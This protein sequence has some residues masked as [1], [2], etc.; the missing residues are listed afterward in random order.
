MS[1]SATDVAAMQAKVN[2]VERENNRLRSEISEMVSTVKS[3]KSSVSSVMDETL[4]VLKTGE[5]VIELDDGKLQNAGVT[6][7]DI[8]QMM[9]RYKSM[10]KAYKT[11]RELN[12][13]LRFHQDGEA[14]VRK[15]LIAMIDNEAQQLASEDTIKEQAEKQYLETQYFFLSYVMMDLVHTK[16]GKKK[17]AERARNK[18][19]EL[20]ERRS[21]WAYF[22]IAL[23]RDDEKELKKWTDRL[24]KTPLVGSEERFLKLLTVIAL[25]DEGE[26]AEKI[27]EYI[28]IDKV[29]SSDKAPFVSK[30]SSEYRSAM[31]I[32]PPEYK[33]I[34]KYVGEAQQLSRALRGAMNNESIV[35]YIR[36]I[37]GGSSSETRS[38]FYSDVFE[39]AV[40]YFRSPKSDDIRKKISDQEKIIE[41]KGDEF[42]AMGLQFEEE[43]KLSAKL[44]I[45]EC[46]YEWL[47][48][49][50]DY[51]GK[52]KIKEFSFNK[53]RASYRRAYVGYV[54]DYRKRYSENLTLKIEDY[55]AQSNFKNYDDDANK[56]VDFLVKKSAKERSTIKDT[57]FILCSVFGAILLIAGIVLNFLTS[58]IPSPYNTLCLVVGVVGGLALAIL[59]VKF[60]YANYQA[61]NKIKERLTSDSVKYAEALKNVYAEVE[62][63]RDK[64]EYYDAQAIDPNQI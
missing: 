24:V 64:Y 7:D 61:L 44:D 1:V 29:D 18:A 38:K 51:A 48:G 15:M 43:A 10:E 6:Q 27:R 49:N 50:D 46:L 5:K 2:K 3:V 53:F 33:N 30:I 54:K 21:V 31:R 39:D 19:L 34:N 62:E 22:L 14:N 60:K 42:D 17:E 20:D 35:E 23:R 56:I 26:V 4:G 8:A 41:A 58:V 11:I 13:E 45:E 9:K 25:C 16:D 52:E 32:N 28:G 57:K 36:K 59:G 12:Q 63:Y 55:T 37:G 47:G 40:E